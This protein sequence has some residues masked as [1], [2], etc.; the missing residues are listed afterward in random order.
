MYETNQYD[1]GVAASLHALLSSDVGAEEESVRFPD[2]RTA[3]LFCGRCGD[4]WCG[5]ISARVE[6][7]QQFVEWSDIAFQDRVTNEIS[8]DG[9]KLTLR[10]ERTAYE[11]TIRALINGWR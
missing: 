10:F 4:I 9:P 3:I 1:A 11:R 6:V 8:L 5:A 7:G 2:G